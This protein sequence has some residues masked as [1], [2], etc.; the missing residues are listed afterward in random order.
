MARTHH[1]A[2]DIDV[3]PTLILSKAVETQLVVDGG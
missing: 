1:F 2:T 3:Q